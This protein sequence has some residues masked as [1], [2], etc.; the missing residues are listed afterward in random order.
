VLAASCNSRAGSI[1][2]QPCWQRPVMM[3]ELPCPCHA[4]TAQV[5]HGCDYL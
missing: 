1:L 2:Q 3:T 5:C 4:D